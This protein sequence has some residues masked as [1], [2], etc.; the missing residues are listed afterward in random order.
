MFA[1]NKFARDQ[2]SADGAVQARFIREETGGHLLRE[3]QQIGDLPRMRLQLTTPARPRAQIGIAGDNDRISEA[4]FERSKVKAIFLGGPLPPK[5]LASN[6]RL[7][8]SH[9]RPYAWVETLPLGGTLGRCPGPLEGRWCTAAGKVSLLPE[10]TNATPV[11]TRKTDFAHAAPSADRTMG[12]KEAIALLCDK[13]TA[14]GA[15]MKSCG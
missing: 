2:A 9:D 10:D 7:R 8:F 11:T 12:A 13:S 14:I 1:C 3:S 5:P 15:K 6:L 4:P